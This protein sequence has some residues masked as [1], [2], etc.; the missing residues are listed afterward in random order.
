VVIKAHVVEVIDA[1]AIEAADEL[2]HTLAE[3]TSMPSLELSPLMSVNDTMRR[4][5]TSSATKGAPSFPIPG[6]D[7]Q[8]AARHAQQA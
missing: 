4:N 6:V 2:P 7:L 8:G 3:F 5:F 1:V